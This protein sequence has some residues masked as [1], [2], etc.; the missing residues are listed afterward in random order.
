MLQKMLI[1]RLWQRMFPNQKRI[2]PTSDHNFSLHAGTL[3]IL[4]LHQRVGRACCFS[5][6]RICAPD[7]LLSAVRLAASAGQYW[8]QALPPSRAAYGAM[9]PNL[10]PEALATGDAHSFF[11]AQMST[12]IGNCTPLSTI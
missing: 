3:P 4:R 2:R 8:T 10:I 7:L 5:Q 9:A 6:D 1:L 12:G 11:A